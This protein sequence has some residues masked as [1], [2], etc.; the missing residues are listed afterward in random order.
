MLLTIEEVAERLRIQPVSARRFLAREGVP[1]VKVGKR[2]LVAA[3]VLDDLIRR[4]TSS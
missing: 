4:H 1:T 2:R 3:E